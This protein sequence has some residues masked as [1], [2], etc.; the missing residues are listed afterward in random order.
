LF[1][2]LLLLFEGL[3]LLLCS[4][5]VARRMRVVHSGSD[6]DGSRDCEPICN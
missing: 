1:L 6:C 3:E 4:S 5:L 2:H